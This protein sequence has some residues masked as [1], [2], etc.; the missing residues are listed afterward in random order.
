M[1][2]LFLPAPRNFYVFPLARMDLPW[3]HAC[4]ITAAIDSLMPGAW[5]RLAG[6]SLPDGYSLE[7][8]L[9]EE[10]DGA[11]YLTSQ[12]RTTEPVEG[13]AAQ[14]ALLKL[15]TAHAAPAGQLTAWERLAGLSHANVL[16]LADC[17][18]A[19]PLGPDGG[20]FLY[21]AFEYPDD[22]LDSALAA[23]PL[24]DSEAR[25]AL[26]A[27][28]AGLEFLHAHGLAHTA[29]DARHIVAVGDRIKLSSDT[30]RPLG[31]EATEADDW[32]ACAALRARLLG[33]ADRGV[34]DA[35][36]ETAPV[37]STEARRPLLPFW[38]YAAL[39]TA[40]VLLLVFALHPKS[41]APRTPVMPAPVEAPAAEAVKPPT[42]EQP[43]E[44]SNWRVVVYTYMR[45]QD[46]E[47]K[48]AQIGARFPGFIPEVFSPNG[49]GRPPYLVALGGRMTRGQARTLQRQ[50]R[51]K[52][53]PSGTYIQNFNN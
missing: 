48:V 43:S 29:V 19:G 1:S 39:A 45:R 52:G 8:Y 17:G 16:A 9:G 11:F 53:M 5:E 4:N 38:G 22:H 6:L 40:L 24:S 49:G 35:S 34:A 26:A 18:R 15:V 47:H 2:I 46:A 36:T 33:E 31:P 3:N 30:V 12:R 42:P 20:Y 50:A 27:V 14:P 10:G 41:P 37:E 44:P 28:Q 21:A 32:K 25:D 13:D 23:G 51:E 7:K